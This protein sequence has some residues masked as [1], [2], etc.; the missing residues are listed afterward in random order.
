MSARVCVCI[1]RAADRACV[2][3]REH[4]VGRHTGAEG[5]ELSRVHSVSLVCSRQLYVLDVAIAVA[6]QSNCSCPMRADSG[7]S[8]HGTV[9]T[10]P[11]HS[12]RTAAA[13]SSE[14]RAALCDSLDCL[15]CSLTPRRERGVRSRSASIQKSF[16]LSLFRFFHLFYYFLR[17]FLDTSEALLRRCALAVA[18]GGATRVHARGSGTAN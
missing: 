2:S 5:C 1:R 4:V 17:L 8:Q 13:P 9:L 10:P 15:T 12:H 16:S 14:T 18:F 3:A 7:C 11:P 6:H